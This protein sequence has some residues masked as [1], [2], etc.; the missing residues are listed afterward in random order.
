V[1]E[2]EVSAR[3]REVQTH[4]V[5]EACYRFLKIGSGLALAGF[6]MMLTTVLFW[7][8]TPIAALGIAVIVWGILSFLRFQ[9]KQG[10][11][12]T[13]PHCDRTYTILPGMQ[14]VLCDECKHEIPVPRAA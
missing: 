5:E 14:H 12:V 1:N 9:R 11:N 13:C 2:N 10:I 4:K 8:G 3:R 7:L 6:A